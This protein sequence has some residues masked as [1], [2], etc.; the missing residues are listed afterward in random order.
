MLGQRYYLYIF[1]INGLVS[2]T[3]FI[4]QLLYKNR[5]NGTLSSLVLSTLAGVI[6]IYVFQTQIKNFPEKVLQRF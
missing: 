2:V 6:L 5:F 1:Y 4:P 3:A